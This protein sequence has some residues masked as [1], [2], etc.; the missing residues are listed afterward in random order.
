MLLLWHVSNKTIRNGQTLCSFTYSVLR[1]SILAQKCNSCWIVA[2]RINTQCLHQLSPPHDVRMF[3]CEMILQSSESTGF[4][5]GRQDIPSEI[6]SL[7]HL[8]TSC[9][10]VISWRMTTFSVTNRGVTSGRISSL[11]AMSYSS[12]LFSAA[13]RYRNCWRVVFCTSQIP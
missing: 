1:L 12:R 13:A 8:N 10:R 3:S 6:A 5:V 7:C 2:E 4:M 9:R 11:A